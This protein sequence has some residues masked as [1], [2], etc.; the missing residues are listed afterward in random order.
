LS[1]IRSV[2]VTAFDLFGILLPGTLLMIA[3]R[4]ALVPVHGS[5][6]ISIADIGYAGWIGIGFA[7][8]I[9]GHLA[10]L[11][12]RNVSRLNALI[13]PWG[14]VFRLSV[15][16]PGQPETT[17]ALERIRDHLQRRTGLD[18][19][20]LSDVVLSNLTDEFLEQYGKASTLAAY[21]SHEV[22]Y[23]GLSG[24]M[25]MLGGA[26]ALCA[27]MNVTTFA[28]LPLVANGYGNAA[29]AAA[30]IVV[31]LSASDAYR[32]QR[33]RRMRHSLLGY[34]ILETGGRLAPGEQDHA[35]SPAPLR[36]DGSR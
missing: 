22:Y 6:A 13:Y 3:I 18:L 34:L 15:E 4:V 10:Q 2:G 24:A 23:R 14:E 19:G 7:C 30:C 32:R 21:R 20:S 28:D 1:D 25:L 16:R 26:F 12:G 17:H 9:A 11:I 35:A 33:R 36:R 29:L 5:I 27:F 8:Y 31:A